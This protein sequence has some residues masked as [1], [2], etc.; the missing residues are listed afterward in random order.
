MN[1]SPPLDDLICAAL[2]KVQ[3]RTAGLLPAFWGALVQD[4]WL[5]W[6]SQVDMPL[7]G[8]L[9]EEGP[10]G[11]YTCSA[12]WLPDREAQMRAQEIGQ[13]V[14]IQEGQIGWLRLTLL[15]GTLFGALSP[16]A[17]AKQASLPPLILND[18]AFDLLELVVDKR[19]AAGAGEGEVSWSGWT[20]Y[21]AL[22]KRSQQRTGSQLERITLEF[23]TPTAFTGEHQHRGRSTIVLPE[24]LLVFGGLARLWLHF[25][26]PDQARTIDPGALALYLEQRVRVERYAL[27]TQQFHLRQRP[28]L[29]FVGRCTFRLSMDDVGDELRRQA[30][31]L[32]DYAF[33]AGLGHKTAQGMGRVRR[34]EE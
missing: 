17:D 7:A 19:A 20:S 30:H 12:L 10:E 2:L 18:I 28:L 21:A 31:L 32:A 14:A 25:A 33:Y 22:V 23:D 27:H 6:V 26:P 29:G 5:N 8:R 34:V 15:D 9:R 24:P 13:S 16:V 3:A 11:P 4:A 1:I